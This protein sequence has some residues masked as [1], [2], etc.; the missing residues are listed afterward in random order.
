MAD[1]LVSIVMAAWRPRREWLLAAVGSALAQTGCRLELIVVD[2]GSPEPVAELLDEIEDERLRVVAVEHG[3]ESRARNAGIE[4]ARGDWLR[5]VDADD[6][7]EPGSTARLLKL[8]AGERVIA[9][10][11][12]AVC[13]EDLRSAWT[14]RSRRSGWIAHDCLLGRWPA[15]VHT[16]LFPR[17]VV[18]AV[19]DWDP[20]FRVSHDWDF[21]LRALDHAPV[22]GDGEIATFYRKHKGA[23]TS[24]TAAGEEGARRVVARYFERHPDLR[25][26]SLERHAHARLDVMA[27][28]VLLS[29][30]RP[31]EA[32][33]R[34]TRGV[35]R[36]P[37]ALIP[38]VSQGLPALRPAFA[39]RRF[40]RSAARADAPVTLPPE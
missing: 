26:T 2:D 31:R 16:M 32:V 29:R 18:E 38:E 23:A 4:V 21:A 22:R 1:P 24:D 14:M 36:D 25:G 12:T 27:G 20:G 10:G 33:R 39:P 34:V 13:D 37:R 5:F 3:G 28:R 15:R 19:G 30:G 11:A 8:A 40:V 17:S 35:L 6:E 9:Y 7:L